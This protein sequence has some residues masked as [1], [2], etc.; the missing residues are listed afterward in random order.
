MRIWLTAF[1]ALLL[2]GCETTPVRP[3]TGAADSRSLSPEENRLWHSAAEMDA[4]LENADYLYEDAEL[5]AYLDAVMLKLYPEYQGT[6]AVR[7]VDSPSLNAFALP[8]GSIYINTGM[9]TR[10]DNE[11]QVATVL[12]HEGVHFTHKHSVQQ[13][14]NVKQS[15]AFSTGFGVVTGIPVVGDLLAMS[16]IFGFS[17]DLEREADA[18]GFL[19]LQAAGYDVTQAPVTFE[20]L[21]AEVEA[22]DI[23]EPYFFSTHPALQ[24][25]IDSFNQLVREYG[26]D[27]GYRGEQAYR[28]QVAKLQ[29][30]LLAD[31]LELGR[32]Q[33]VLLILKQPDA[34]DRYPPTA[35]FYLGEAYRLRGDDGDAGRSVAAY[36]Q[37]IRQVP[38]FAPTYRALGLYHMKNHNPEQAD[39]YFARYLELQPDASDRG[40][41]EL[42]R[43]NLKAKES[44]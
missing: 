7:A 4:Q 14:R 36:T 10:L 22:L 21:L 3:M 6:I 1:A 15:T 32:Y 17:K 24:D 12:A 30:Q 18:E 40:Y 13:R 43:A 41:V 20:F 25:R 23:D 8:N 44:Q 33:S 31:Y 2:A 37:A 42:Y 27:N 5:Q 28:A 26:S 16:S 19:R 38:E 11:A 9:L 35:W 29:V 39:R 34:F